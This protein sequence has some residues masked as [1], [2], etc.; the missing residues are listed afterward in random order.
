MP[1]R[2]SIQTQPQTTVYY[3][4]NVAMRHD[5]QTPGHGVD[6]HSPIACNPQ[7]SDWRNASPSTPSHTLINAHIPRMLATQNND[8]VP[9]HYLPRVSAC[10]PSSPSGRLYAHPSDNQNDRPPA[11]NPLMAS[12]LIVISSSIIIDLMPMTN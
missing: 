12:I 8:T 5:D 6:R 10:T 7:I 3:P 9:D 11:A 4:K 2:P 1:V